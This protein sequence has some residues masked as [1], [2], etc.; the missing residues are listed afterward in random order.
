MSHLL[1]VS[2]FLPVFIFLPV[3]MF[4][5]VSIFLPVIMHKL[6]AP[7]VSSCMITA[8]GRAGR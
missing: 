7:V 4:L 1:P 8:E 3:T 6:T 5:P 2:I